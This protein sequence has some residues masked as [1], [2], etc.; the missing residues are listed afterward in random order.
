MTHFEMR[1]SSSCVVN[2]AC[3]TSADVFIVV[4]IFIMQVRLT[5]LIT[6]YFVCR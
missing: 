3:Q 6:D 1:N 2:Y 4:C 5:I